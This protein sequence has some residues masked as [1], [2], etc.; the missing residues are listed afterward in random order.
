MRLEELTDKKI[1]EVLKEGP[2]WGKDL[3]HKLFPE[4]QWDYRTIDTVRSLCGE[5]E[6]KGKLKFN[7]RMIELVS[8]SKISKL[9]SKRFEALAPMGVP[10]YIRCYDNEGESADRYTAVYSG[11]QGGNFV[12]MS[13][14]PYHPQ[15]MGQ[16][17]EG[18]IDRD[19]N[20]WPP[21]YGRKCHLGTRVDFFALPGKCQQLV[22]EEY[23]EDW[24]L[25]PD[26][27]KE[28][29]RQRVIWYIDQQRGI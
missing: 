13:S 29:F 24:K 9:G 28:A 4:G 23:A 6:R 12:A 5:L 15:G 3:I 10:R 1:L 17:G 20:G 2:L 11:K 21:D 27:L 7:E 19:H 18:L 25:D 22:L 16:H 14:D 26:D 8:Q